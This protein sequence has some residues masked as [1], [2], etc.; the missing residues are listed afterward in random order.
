MAREFDP[1]NLATYSKTDLVA[2]L[3][4]LGAQPE[5]KTFELVR[6]A[7]EVK[8]AE[9]NEAALAR[10]ANSGRWLSVALLLATVVGAVGTVV[11]AVA[12]FG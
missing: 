12:A 3:H 10:T 8:I 5:S 11:G 6:L 9:D 2:Y 4:N 7:L 1:R